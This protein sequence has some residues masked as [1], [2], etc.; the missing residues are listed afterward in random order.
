MEGSRSDRIISIT[1]G[2][3]AGISVGISVLDILGILPGWAAKLTP[4]FVGV[5]LLYVVLERERMESLKF[6]LRRLDKGLDRMRQEL[7][8]APPAERPVE[9]GE[10]KPP[11]YR[12][13]PWKGMIFRSN[14]ELRVA[15]A[16]DHQSVVFLP[17][18]KVRLSAGD[19]RQSR[20]VD[21]LVFHAGRWGV[22]EVDGPWHTSAGD[23]SRDALLRANG[24]SCIQ[25]VGSDRAYHETAAV[26][27]EFLAFLGACAES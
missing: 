6:I 3:I 22:L 1:L 16:L 21:F 13:I 25:R 26:V 18:T 20:E 27:A 8:S 11:T 19:E 5:L 7:G 9:A 2:A 4:F 14:T 12:A 15:K 17:P 10:P 24:I 23:A